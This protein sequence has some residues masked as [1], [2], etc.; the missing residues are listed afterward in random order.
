M[1]EV[2]EPRTCVLGGQTRQRRMFGRLSTGAVI[3]LSVLGLV[4]VAAIIVVRSWLVVVLGGLLGLLIVWALTKITDEGDG[5]T[6]TVLDRIRFRLQIGLR[7]FGRTVVGGHPLWIPE[8]GDVPSVIGPLREIDA[9]T[10]LGDFSLLHHA[11]PNGSWDHG[12]LTGMF[13][14]IG[15]G[16]GLRETQETNAGGRKF[17]TVLRTLS[18]P[19]I[20]ID[21]LDMDTRAMPT[22]PSEYRA[23]V[24]SLLSPSCPPRLRSSMEE[25][26]EVGVGFSET[27][28]SFV[29]VRMPL[30]QVRA[31]TY[32][33]EDLA[34][35]VDTATEALRTAAERFM[36][37]GFEVRT[38]LGP[39][40]VA[41]YIR[42]TYVPSWSPDD[43][44]GLETLADAWAFFG[45]D[46][47]D[48]RGRS[49]RVEA[50]DK[51]EWWHAVATIPVDAWPTNEVS[52]R[53]LEGLVTDTSSAVIRTVRAQHRLVSKRTARE[54]AAVG[55]TIDEADLYKEA[56]RGQAST[57]ETEAQASAARRVLEDLRGGA[58]GD[59]PAVRVLVSARDR[60]DLE[61]A[62]GVIEAAADD[63]GIHR[64]HW[65]DRRHDLA[66]ALMCPFG[67]GVKL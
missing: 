44:S 16:D 45:Y 1:L 13:E 21:Q 62:R 23:H 7:V 57:G 46:H 36:H 9:P 63:M 11:A 38:V 34:G 15:D 33:E 3:V 67:K 56:K 29:T 47:G 2:Q 27:Y 58:A 32:G 64:L 14:V 59:V 66:M 43:L 39:R 42:H 10:A 26:T 35:V 31:K 30:D 48:H 61:D 52:V 53:W 22:D 17:G 20:P 60:F 37:N 54:R 4:W 40:R 8:A 50:L 55:L 41:A 49:L 65:Y 12:H 51:G 24:A 28:R 6:R 5:W 25:V 19:Q 18:A